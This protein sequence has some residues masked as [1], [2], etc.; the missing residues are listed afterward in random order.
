M[1]RNAIPRKECYNYRLYHKQCSSCA[2]VQCTPTAVALGRYN[3][4]Y[5]FL[6]IT[7]FSCSS[8]AFNYASIAVIEEYSS[9]P[10]SVR[11]RISA[12]KGLTSYE[13]YE[14]TLKELSLAAQEEGTNENL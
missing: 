3:H 14:Q 5:T 10:I 4:V 13:L 6:R 7:E 9:I 8:K 2:V 11:E 1:K 12:L